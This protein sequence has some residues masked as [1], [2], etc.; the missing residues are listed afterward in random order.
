MSEIKS[1]LDGS[2]TLKDSGF[3]VNVG[4]VV[5]NEKKVLLTSNPAKTRLIYATDIGKGGLK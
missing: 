2:T 1:L 3:S 5:W 4:K